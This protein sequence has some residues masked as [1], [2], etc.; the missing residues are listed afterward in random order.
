MNFRRKDA[1]GFEFPA[2]I[3]KTNFMK[4]ETIY[5]ADWVRNTIDKCEVLSQYASYIELKR[6][7]AQPMNIMFHAKKD[8]FAQ[9]K[10]CST[11]N[12]ALTWIKDRRLQQIEKLEQQLSVSKKRLS[13]VV[14][15]YE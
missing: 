1:G 15:Y 12:E 13:D 4:N 6:S 11:Y 7:R 5:L 2:R 10:I 9:H 3:P 14:K 8:N